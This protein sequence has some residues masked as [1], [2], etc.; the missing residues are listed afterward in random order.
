MHLKTMLWLWGALALL[1]ASCEKQTITQVDAPLQVAEAL[2]GGSTEGY[3][4][5]VEVRPFQFPLDHGPHP[6]FRN[7]W[8]YFT[9]NLSTASGRR[10]GYQFTLFRTALAPLD[11]RPNQTAWEQNQVFMGHFALTDVAS[12][13]FHFAERFSRDALGL[14][15]AQAQPFQVWLEDWS[16]SGDGS[17]RELPMRLV[18]EEGPVR[19]ELDLIAEKPMVLQGNQGLSQKGGEAGNASYYYSYT[20]LKASGSVTVEGETLPV[21][22]SSWMDREWSTSALESGQAG[23]DWFALQLSDGSELMY[24]Q[25]RL[26]DGRPDRTSAGVRVF[27]E[28]GTTK[29]SW[30]DVELTPLGFWESPHTGARYPSGWRLQSRDGSVDLQIQPVLKDQELRVTVHYW[31]GAVDIQ[32]TASGKPVSGQGYVELTGYTPASLLG[33]R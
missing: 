31:E 8:W 24:Y 20:R 29:L 18:A 9:G 25:L 21:N 26:E 12:G 19:M 15:G 10:F 4:R 11:P 33:K 16:V 2:G 22:G 30:E 7:E 3:A 6:E 28:G 5:A 14:S 27:P 23:W 13:K 17:R 32:G 1:L